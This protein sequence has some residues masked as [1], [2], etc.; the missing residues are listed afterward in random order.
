MPTPIQLWGDI[1]QLGYV[2]PEPTLEQ[3][4][5]HWVKVRGVGPWLVVEHPPVNDF[6]HRGAGGTL[7]FTFALAQAGSM[8]IELIVQH[9]DQPSTYTEFLTA[10]HGVGGLHHLA[11]WPEDMDAAFAEATDVLGYEL[12][13]AGRIGP[14]GQFRYFLTSH[15][16]AGDHPG[17]VVEHANIRPATRAFFADMAEQSRRFD[18][19]TDAWFVSR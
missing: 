10:T 4:I 9:N 7:D 17:T 11:H 12:W 16:D 15:L 18:A 5:E 19:A 1:R 6:L 2:I 8:Q 3:A 14:E 13:T